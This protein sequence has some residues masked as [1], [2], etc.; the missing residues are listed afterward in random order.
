MIDPISS[1]PL[2]W[3]LA[4]NRWYN[5]IIESPPLSGNPLLMYI[6]CGPQQLTFSCSLEKTV[7]AVVFSKMLR[8]LKSYFGFSEHHIYFPSFYQPIIFLLSSIFQDDFIFLSCSFKYLSAN[9]NW[10]LCSHCSFV[11]SI[12][13]SSLSQDLLWI[14]SCLSHS[15]WLYFPVIF[16]SV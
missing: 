12:C 16:L 7:S 8:E 10:N 9:Q 14:P 4:Q 3:S 2:F 13:V 6:D 5:V 11:K 15:V 1:M